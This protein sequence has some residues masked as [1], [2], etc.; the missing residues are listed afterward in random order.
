MPSHRAGLDTPLEVL[1]SFSLAP[2]PRFACHLSLAHSSSQELCSL[3]MGPTSIWMFLKH[4]RFHTLVDAR[5]GSAS[6]NITPWR[7][8]SPV[9]RSAHVIIPKNSDNNLAMGRP[10][11]LVVSPFDAKYGRNLKSAQLRG[12]QERLIDLQPVSL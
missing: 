9:R 6:P 5:G 1:R 4:S 12:S 10:T 3:S 7:H 11:K 2:R 8:R